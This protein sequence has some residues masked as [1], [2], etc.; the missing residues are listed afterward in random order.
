MHYRLHKS[1]EE[2]QR[3][4]FACRHKK[5]IWYTV[6]LLNIER[7]GS[8]FRGRIA[9]KLQS[10]FRSFR[11]FP[12]KCLTQV[13]QYLESYHHR[14]LVQNSTWYRTAAAYKRIRQFFHSLQSLPLNFWI[15]E[16]P[17]ISEAS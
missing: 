12:R 17:T 1:R 2:A 9:C 13:V 6:A 16:N 8:D 7:L 11:Y 5:G 15:P 14:S 4:A 3:S 10:D